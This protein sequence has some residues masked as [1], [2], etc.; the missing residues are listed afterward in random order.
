[1]P[2]DPGVPA[3]SHF[4]NSVGPSTFAHQAISFSFDVGFRTIAAIGEF[5]SFQLLQFVGCNRVDYVFG[6]AQVVNCV[7][8]PRKSGRLSRT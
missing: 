1:M 4:S 2:E 5:A 3:A 6:N 7:H 8:F